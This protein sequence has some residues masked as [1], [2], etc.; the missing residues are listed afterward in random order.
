VLPDV[1]GAPDEVAVEDVATE[2]DGN[3]GIDA[4]TSATS[5]HVLADRAWVFDDAQDGDRRFSVT[6]GR[7]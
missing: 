2:A 1:I 7:P 4:P 5:R 6:S 3:Q